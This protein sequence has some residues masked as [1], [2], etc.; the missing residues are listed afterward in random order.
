MNFSFIKVSSF[1]FFLIGITVLI[2]INLSVLDIFLLKNNDS[3]TKKETIETPLL[4]KLIPENSQTLKPSSPLSCPE[5]CTSQIYQA[6]SSI[7]LA[8]LASTIVPT[9]T[10]IPTPTILPTV[11]PSSVVKEF[12]IPLGSGSS[13]ASDWTDVGGVSANIDNSQY[14][15][16]KNVT[17]EASV[18][19]PTGNETAYIR[20]YNVTDKH[21]VWYSDLFLEGGI[22]KLLV[23]KPISLDSGNK[24]YQVQMKT[25]LQYQAVL[26][27]ARIHITTN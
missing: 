6:T 12:F 13:T 17:F 24:L 14:G 22:A 19:I 5:S 20:L 18:Y 25:S 1:N 10:P 2:I 9:S 4:T 8:Q 26:S 3:I 16:I 7:K 21:P 27:Q 15:Q 23:S 11:P